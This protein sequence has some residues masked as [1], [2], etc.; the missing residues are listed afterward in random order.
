MYLWCEWIICNWN[1][2]HKLQPQ[3][4]PQRWIKWSLT[5]SQRFLIMNCRIYRAV[6]PAWIIS[7]RCFRYCVDYFKGRLSKLTAPLLQNYCP[8]EPLNRQLDNSCVWNSLKDWCAQLSFPGLKK[9]NFTPLK[10]TRISILFPF[11]QKH[12]ASLEHVNKHTAVDNKPRQT[13]SRLKVACA[14]LGEISTRWFGKSQEGSH[15]S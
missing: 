7:C 15:V 5:V 6:V 14:V 12:C 2:N 9:E 3:T 11:C 1:H 4:L 13:F 8:S 10:W